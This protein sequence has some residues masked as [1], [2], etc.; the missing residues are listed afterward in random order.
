MNTLR[1]GTSNDQVKSLAKKL[2]SA[3]KKQLEGWRG[4]RG[5]QKGEN[6]FFGFLA[7]NSSEVARV[8]ARSSESTP[9]GSPKLASTPS[10]LKADT[11]LLQSTP[12]P[13]PKIK[14]EGIKGK[15][16]IINNTY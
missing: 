15:E 10:E 14:E 8:R 9:K 4:G 16:L 6:I 5:S 12:P 3:W 1:K 7:E 2:I 11:P 13:P